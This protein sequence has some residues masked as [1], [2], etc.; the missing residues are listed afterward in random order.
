MPIFVALTGASSIAFD[1]S[2]DGIVGE[3]QHKP[4]DRN[5]DDKGRNAVK[6][7]LG[8]D[9][10]QNYTGD[11]IANGKL[12]YSRPSHVAKNSCVRL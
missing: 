6:E 5:E 4:I 7:T 8:E 12:H 11:C 1:D 3:L 9:D 2:P 10:M